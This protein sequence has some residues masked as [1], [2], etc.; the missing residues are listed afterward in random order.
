[1]EYYKDSVTITEATASS[2]SPGKGKIQINLALENGTQG[3]K[4]ILSQV[5][6][7][8]Q[9]LA[10]LVSNCKLNHVGVYWH[11][12][13]WTLFRIGNKK[14]LSYVPLVNKSQIFKTLEN[15]NI[16]IHLAQKD[17]KIYQWPEH[18]MV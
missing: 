3:S 15:L 8:P 18:A 7:M 11:S 5:M 10:N 4:M 1:M 6:Y 16:A 2:I 12:V 17:N 9:C 14:I 13:N